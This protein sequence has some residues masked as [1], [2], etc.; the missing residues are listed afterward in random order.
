[1]TTRPTPPPTSPSPTLEPLLTIADLAHLLHASRRSV[2][3][4]KSSGQLPP[5][6][7]II[8]RMPRWKPATVRTWIDGQA[9]GRGK[10]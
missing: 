10:R 7:L 9:A 6:D 3:R 1:M 2:E 8:G 5:A 4:L